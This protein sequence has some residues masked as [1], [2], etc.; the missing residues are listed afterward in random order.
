MNTMENMT[1]S[2]MRFQIFGFEISHVLLSSII[3]PFYAHPKPTTS[4]FYYHRPTQKKNTKY[5]S[6]KPNPRRSSKAARAVG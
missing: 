6:I 5:I 2:K 4:I 1:Q 3:S